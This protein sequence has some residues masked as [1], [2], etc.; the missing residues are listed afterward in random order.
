MARH[1]QK[2]KLRPLLTAGNTSC[3]IQEKIRHNRLLIIILTLSTASLTPT[4]AAHNATS[5][6]A[7]ATSLNDYQPHST[8]TV[9]VSV[10]TARTQFLTSFHSSQQP[11][12]TAVNSWLRYIHWNVRFGHKTRLLPL[13]IWNVA[14]SAAWNEYPSRTP[15]YSCCSPLVVQMRNRII[16]GGAEE[17]HVFQMVSTRQGWG[18]WR[19]AW[20]GGQLRVFVRNSDSVVTV[21][22]LFRRKF[23]VEAFQP[24]AVQCFD[25]QLRLDAQHG[26]F[27]GKDVGQ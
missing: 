20:V 25:L 27:D 1:N 15:Q 4:F 21:Q 23:N 26:T 19:W 18:W 6:I 10:L 17:T 11:P 7:T 16:Q 8:K 5:A 3:I 2:N 13:P 14:H 22:R 24:I 9:S 12:G